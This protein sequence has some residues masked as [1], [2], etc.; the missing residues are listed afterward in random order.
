[1]FATNLKIV[2][3]VALTLAAYSLVASMIPQIESEVP[4]EL[5]LSAGVTEDELIAA[6]ERLYNGAGGCMACHGLGTR[7]PYLLR[8][9]GGLGAIG[10]RC[11]ERVAGLSCKEYLYQSLVD[12]RAYEVEGY[13][14]IMPDARRLLSEEQ[15][16]ALVAF[17][18]SQGGVVT[19]SA[20]DLEQAGVGQAA[21]P[22]TGAPA[23]TPTSPLAAATDPV[24]LLNELGCLAC[25]KLGDQ[26][27]ALG[28]A[29]TDVGARRDADY[30]REAILDPAADISAG[31]EPFAGTMP[32]NFGERITA[33]QLESLVRFL[34]EQR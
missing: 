12:P 2:L 29:L 15:I 20:A 11:G 16:W 17:L 32:A 30:I 4:E 22:P 3:V 27:N 10:V 21:G 8:G 19:V 28:P 9:E 18:E 26:G 33:A 31:Y 14:P 6:G 34:A 7:A 5:H 25:H 23:A 24:E 13:N 1:M